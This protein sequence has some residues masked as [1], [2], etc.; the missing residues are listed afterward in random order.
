MNNASS[1]DFVELF[2]ALLKTLKP[3]DDSVIFATS[4]DDTFETLKSDSLD[5]M[6]IIL[7]ICE[8]YGVSEETARTFIPLSIKDI[9]DF[10]LLHKTID[11]ES[12]EEILNN[13]K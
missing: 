9:Q 7:Y 8:A 10:I 11:P 13:L 6:M 4:L 5:I 3:D 12:I 1:I 2:N